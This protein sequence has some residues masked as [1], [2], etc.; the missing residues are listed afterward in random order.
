MKVGS[1][2]CSIQSVLE[3]FGAGGARQVQSNGWRPS[4]QHCMGSPCLAHRFEAV[5]DAVRVKSS[6]VGALRMLLSLTSQ[7]DAMA[8]SAQKTN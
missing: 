1:W 6:N 3:P 8:I 4:H 5:A 7:S 2:K